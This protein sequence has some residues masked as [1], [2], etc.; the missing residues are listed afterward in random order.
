[1]VCS[2]HQPTEQQRLKDPTDNVMESSKKK[3]QS[4]AKPQ[5][6]HSGRRI[7]TSAAL[8][9]GFQSPTNRRDRQFF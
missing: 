7:A 4:D 3:W 6:L 2:A 9:S 5:R 1:M 8:L